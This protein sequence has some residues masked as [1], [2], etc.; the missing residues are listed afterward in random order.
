MNHTDIIHFYSAIRNRLKAFR[1]D[2]QSD[3]KVMQARLSDFYPS[4]SLASV[5]LST[6]ICFFRVIFSVVFSLMQCVQQRSSY[7]AVGLTPHSPFDLSFHLLACCL[8]VFFC[9]SPYPRF[10][11]EKLA[12]YENSNLVNAIPDRFIQ[13]RY[14]VFTVSIQTIFFVEQFLLDSKPN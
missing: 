12:K 4:S 5:A 13:C 7:R 1:V 8:K 3:L 11:F 2:L 14:S 10:Y 9:L 6:S